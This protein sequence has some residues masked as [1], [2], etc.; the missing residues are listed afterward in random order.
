[1]FGSDGVEKTEVLRQAGVARLLGLSEVTIK[2]MRARGD[3]PPP[4]RIGLRAVG[5]MRSELLQWLTE[6]PIVGRR[7]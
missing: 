7:S 3:L 2:R 1:M 4:R 5:W 6:R